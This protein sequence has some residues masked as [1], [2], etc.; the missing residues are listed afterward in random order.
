M[1][2]SVP[3]PQP[4]LTNCLNYSDRHAQLQWAWLDGYGV[5][6]N[7]AIHRWEVQRYNTSYRKWET[8]HVAA[9]Y[10][11]RYDFGGNEIPYGDSNARFRLVAFPYSGNTYFAPTS[12]EIYIYWD[13]YLRCGQYY[14]VPSNAVVMP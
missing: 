6:A 1:K 10:H 3:F 7:N 13:G 8:V 5:P 12:S 4:R 9:Q 14:A 11:D 2:L